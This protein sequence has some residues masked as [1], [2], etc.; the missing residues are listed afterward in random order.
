MLASESYERLTQGRFA[1][2]RATILL[3]GLPNPVGLKVLSRN[4]LQVLDMDMNGVPISLEDEND[5]NRFLRH[6]Q[7]AL[8]GRKRGIRIS[9][10]LASAL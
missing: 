5:T 1:E 9:T 3:D 7:N 2:E 4:Y 8:V 10:H 6:P